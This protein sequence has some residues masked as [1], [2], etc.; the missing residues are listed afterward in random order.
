MALP[1]GGLLS[2]SSALLH[3][4]T[5]RCPLLGESVGGIQFVLEKPTRQMTSDRE[6]EREMCRVNIAMFFTLQ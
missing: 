4:R 1:A 3:H 6:A 2:S 5:S